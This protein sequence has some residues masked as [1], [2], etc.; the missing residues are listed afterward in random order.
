VRPLFASRSAEAADLARSL[1]RLAA[2]T[3]PLVLQ[4]ETG[5]GKSHLAALAHRRSRPGKPLVVVDCGALAASL[6]PAE[7][8]GHAHGAFTDA[9]RARVG[10]LERAGEGTLVLDRVDA[11]PVEGQAV[12][13]RVLEEQRFVPVGAT[14]ARR[15]AARVVAL[16]D[17]GLAGRVASGAFR[18]DLYHRLAGFVAELPPL[19]RR[20]EDI[21]PFAHAA[22]RRRH[23]TD[24]RLS[25]EAERLLGAY[26]WPG[27]F[28]ELDTVLERLCLLSDGGTVGPADLGLPADAWPATAELAAARLL[29]LVEV[30][31]LYAL[32]VLARCGGNV[33]R[34]ARAL[35]VSRRTVIRWRAS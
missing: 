20:R 21:L 9:T 34:T 31:R 29:P 8:F 27:N 4:G 26:P 23:R 35:G 15:L 16:A 12:L 6:L 17:A 3:L 18:A 7:L 28:R 19:R 11:L 30:E 10:L 33:S 2:T 5:T 24:L 1:A 32:H 25:G 13:L 14:T 22:L